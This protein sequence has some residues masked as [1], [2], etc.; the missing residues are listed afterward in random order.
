[1]AN[2]CSPLVYPS[3]LVDPHFSMIQ[4][5]HK[6]S[7][8]IFIRLLFQF[9]FPSQTAI[10]LPFLCCQKPPRFSAELVH[11]DRARLSQHHIPTETSQCS[12]YFDK[13]PKD[14]KENT[15]RKLSWRQTQCGKKRDKISKANKALTHPTP[16]QIFA[17]G[18][19]N[20]WREARRKRRF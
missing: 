6:H 3:N 5:A 14:N 19:R 13:P 8:S 9:S 11:K 20:F 12:H 17:F 4:E 15:S 10:V 16:N 2:P 1:M 7:I 18:T